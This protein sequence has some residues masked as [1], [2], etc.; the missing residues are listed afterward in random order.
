MPELP[1]VETIK[2]A[3]ERSIGSSN[4]VKVSVNNKNLREKIPEDFA[5]KVEG[6]RITGYQRRAKYIIITLDNG[7]SVILHLG[8]SGKI[9]ISD[10]LPELVKHDHVVI[11]TDKGVIVLND[12]RRFGILT[13]CPTEELCGHRFFK[14]NGLEPFDKALTADYLLAK[15]KN[16]KIPV[17]VALL[18]QSIITGIGNIYAS[19]ALYQAGI[20]PVK[21]AGSLNREDCR[22][23]IEKVIAVLNQ[24]IAAGGST[25]KDYQKPDGSLGY[26]QNKHCV[27]NKTGQ[28]CPHCC[29]DINQTGG[30]QKIVL[31]GRSTFFCPVKQK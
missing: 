27:Y 18:D 17:K 2:T 6:A 9:K 12:A 22:I 21:E 7:L 3:I 15:F 31:G 14:K 13:Y 16:K 24:A 25:L 8:M 5:D 1:E 10:T 19:E 20:L 26:F 28:K 4:I 30:I 23:L 11:E 29:C